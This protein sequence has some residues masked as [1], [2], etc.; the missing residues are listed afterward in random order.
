MILINKIGTFKKSKFDDIIKNASGENLTKGTHF[1]VIAPYSVACTKLNSNVVT[2]TGA[3]HTIEKGDD[4]F[5]TGSDGI[6]RKTFVKDIGET[7]IQLEDNITPSNSTSITL[8][9]DF[10]TIT[11][12][13][14]TN[15]VDELYYFSDNEILI[16]SE[17]YLN[18]YISYSSL[19]SYWS[20]LSRN[21]NMVKLNQEALKF[22]LGSFSSSPDFYKKL[23]SNNIRNAVILQM[24]VMVISDLSARQDAI[25]NYE[26][27]ID[28]MYAIISRDSSNIVSPDPTDDVYVGG[29]GTI[30]YGAK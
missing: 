11:L 21:I 29:F 6:K 7:T 1:T 23:D 3:S 15:T 5:V 25:K 26:D 27:Y 17:H 30:V 4:V 2:I 13:L 12:N 19:Y 16:V 18:L 28:K 10:Y 20:G 22:V 24:L 8:E 14:S 9:V